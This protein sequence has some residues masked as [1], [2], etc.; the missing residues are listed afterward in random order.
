M[1]NQSKSC[2]FQPEASIFPQKRKKER[3]NQEKGEKEKHEDV[4]PAHAKA[5]EAIFHRKV[6]LSVNRVSRA[7]GTSSTPSPPPFKIVERAMKIGK[8]AKFSRAEDYQGVGG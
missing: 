8:G 7:G 1:T 3:K 2:N 4:F 5:E 6:C